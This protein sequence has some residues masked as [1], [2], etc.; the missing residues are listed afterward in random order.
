MPRPA[1]C[2]CGC[3]GCDAEKRYLFG[4]AGGR[5]QVIQG[6]HAALQR[7]IDIAVDARAATAAVVEIPLAAR[8]TRTVAA[9]AVRQIEA[10]LREGEGRAQPE[11]SC[12]VCFE[13]YDGKEHQAV[14]LGCGHVTCASC[15]TKLQRLDC[16]KCR[17]PIEIVVLLYM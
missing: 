12:C 11:G 4:L 10:R 6:L 9:E 15:I 14:A 17:N 1:R 8:T 3:A 13:D 16:P 7:T 2:R 5:G